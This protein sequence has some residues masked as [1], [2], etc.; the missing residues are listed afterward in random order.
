MV[1]DAATDRVYLSSADYTAS[2][3]TPAG[4]FTDMKWALARTAATTATTNIPA[5]PAAIPGS[6]TVIVVGR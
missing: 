3:E 6:F 2:L 5:H 4:N 1:Y